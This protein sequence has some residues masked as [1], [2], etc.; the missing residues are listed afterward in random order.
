MEE[1]GALVQNETGEYGTGK[2]KRLTGILENNPK[3]EMHDTCWRC[4]LQLFVV[5]VVVVVVMVAVV[6]VM[7]VVVL[8]CTYDVI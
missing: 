6:V 7:A 1:T 3:D 2:G 8:L 4:K 5:V